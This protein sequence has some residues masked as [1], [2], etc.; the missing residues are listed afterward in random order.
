MRRAG[1]RLV[2]LTVCLCTMSGCGTMFNL[3]GHEPWLMGPAPMRPITPF[4]GIDND[5]RVMKRGKSA[6]AWESGPIVAGVIDMPFSFF[7][8]VVT[9]PWTTY[10]ALRPS[11]TGMKLQFD[12]QA[13]REEVLKHVSVGMPIET[14]KQLM[15][16]SGFR[17]EEGW[18][19]C[20]NCLARYKSNFFMS[21]EIWVLLHHEDGKLSR[22]EVDCHSVG[23]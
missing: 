17:C 13:M 18:S 2:V 6:D 1:T 12:N 19:S 3:S 9:L 14:A 10:Q 5:V 4:G 20:L 8:D 15:E 23:P 16:A 7:G 21:D 11:R 22:I